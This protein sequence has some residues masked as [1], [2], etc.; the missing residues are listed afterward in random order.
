MASFYEIVI[1]QG[2]DVTLPFELYDSTDKPL[3]LSGF[4]ARMQVRQSAGSSTFIDE[5]TTE[6]GRLTIEGGTI[7][8]E[9]KNAK[10][11]EM[12]AGR[13]VYDIE[14]VSASDEV[15]RILEGA[16]VLRKEVTR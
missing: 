1:D 4:K 6:N 10:T 14:I 7:K 9:W 8:A 5:L 13:Y 12:V 2:T 15:T 16:F 3:N 11:S